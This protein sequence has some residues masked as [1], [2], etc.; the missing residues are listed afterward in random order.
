MKQRFVSML[1]ILGAVVVG[2]G[3]EDQSASSQGVSAAGPGITYHLTAAPEPELERDG[4]FIGVKFP[5]FGPTGLVADVGVSGTLQVV[6][7]TPTSEDVTLEYQIIGVDITSLNPR[8]LGDIS[9]H[10]NDIGR[11]QLH[12]DGTLSM[13]LHI[14]ILGVNYDLSAYLPEPRQ[15]P[16]ENGQL[17]FRGVFLRTAFDE[18]YFGLPGLFLWADPES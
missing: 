4:S 10:G 3:S 2:C 9:T 18:P 5:P 14:P 15:Y 12:R 11:I 6:R 8:V 13:E 7:E 16:L 1:C 17:L